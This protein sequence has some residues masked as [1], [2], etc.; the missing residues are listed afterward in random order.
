[1]TEAV[2][3]SADSQP[4]FDMRGIRKAFGATVAVDGVDLSV[5]PGEVC[6]IVGQNGAG[7]STLMGILA[8]ALRPDAG[9]MTLGGAPYHPEHPLDARRAGVAMIY[10]ELS[11][12]P[13]LS[14]AE[15]ILLGMEPTWGAS[16]LLK[17]D[18]MR[19][20]AADVLVRLGHPEI[21]SNAT[22]GSLSPAS[23]QL[24]EIG[25]AL[26]VGC[27]VLVLDE[28]TSSLARDDTRRLFE[29]IGELKRQGHA[30]VYISHFIEEVKEVADRIV[31]LRD[32]RVVGG[33]MAAQLSATEIV[34]LMVG[35]PVDALYP[36]SA[37]T[38]GD[39]ILEVAGYGPAAATLTLHR[40]EIVGVAGLL[41]AGRTRFLRSLFGLEPVRT[42]RV[43][44]ATWSGPARPHERWQ[45]GMGFLSE[46]RKDEGL[47]GALSIANNMTL[48]RLDGLGPGPFVLKGHQD[49]A[50]ASWM[51]RLGIRA[52]GPRQAVSELSGGNQQK[53]AMARLLHHDV[54][55]FVLD[56]PTKGID[57]A[58]KA[59]IYELIDSLV[60][61]SPGAGRTSPKAVL[62][63]S[64]Y[65]P[66]LLGL[67]DRV[68]VMCRGRLGTPR[69]VGEW[70]EHALMLAATGAG[71]A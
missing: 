4:L 37:R 48:S 25:R 34:Q 30:I 20:R 46:D 13:H 22:A 10:Q 47:A 36:H 70:T 51:E 43:R 42:G 2:P 21:A 12:A 29:L 27:R 15:N 8:G 58:S 26:A 41:G 62:M 32:G 45:Q 64:S 3:M 33:G 67:C 1:V 19:R 59:Q 53:V 28:P 56:E 40:G 66:E 69:P 17:R 57:V 9:S 71:E 11:L 61:A 5:A 16:G 35:R 18:E 39:A 60:S 24:V 63:V 14:V 49:R 7:K 52:R 54:D 23:Q 65:I 50:A 6:A 68:A 31:V 55:V 38:Q 44:L